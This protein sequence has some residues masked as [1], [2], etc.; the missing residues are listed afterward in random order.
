MI[1]MLQSNSY[2]RIRNI[3]ADRSKKNISVLKEKYSLAIRYQVTYSITQFQFNNLW[4]NQ[5]RRELTV[6][7]FQPCQKI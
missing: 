5:P 6:I 7:Y 3:I 1:A 2:T 4:L